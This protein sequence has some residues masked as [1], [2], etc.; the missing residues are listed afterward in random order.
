MI[1]E[2]WKNTYFILD[3]ISIV[4]MGWISK[5]ISNLGF[6]HQNLYLMI[7]L[8]TLLNSFSYFFNHPSFAFLILQLGNGESQN[9]LQVTISHLKIYIQ[10]YITL[11]NG[12]IYF[13]PP[14]A[15]PFHFL[16]IGEGGILKCIANLDSAPQNLYS[17]M[18]HTSK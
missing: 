4:G 6:T 18:Y 9:A 17:M 16:P 7:Y 12:S 1:I 5:Y 2:T 10:W 14:F 8:I 11:L 13:T 15:F 3:C